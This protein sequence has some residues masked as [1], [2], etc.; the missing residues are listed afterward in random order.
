MSPVTGY[1]SY[2]SVVDE[3]ITV[4]TNSEAALGGPP[5]GAIKVRGGYG[6]PE[7][8]ADRA[9]LSAAV[10]DVRSTQNGWHIA[11]NHRDVK[12]SLLLS[13]GKQIRAGVSSQIAGTIFEGAIARNPRFGVAEG[14]FLNT[15]EE[16]ADVWF[17]IDGSTAIANSTGPP[18]V[19]GNYTLAAFRAD[20]AAARAAYVAVHE[21]HNTLMLAR[22]Y[23]DEVWAPTYQH[24]KEFRDAVVA[25]FPAGDPILATVPV[26]TPAAGSTPRGVHVAIAWDRAQEKAVSITRPEP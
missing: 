9:I 10:T 21:A 20:I 14:E 6:L 4:W 15:F 24:L 25:R 19:A 2:V 11:G 12:K 5:G 13:R 1:L 8:T 23:R 22:R 17:R 7:I 16:M 3:N 18:V 26:L